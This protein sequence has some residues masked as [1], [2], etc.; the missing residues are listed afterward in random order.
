MKPKDFTIDVNCPECNSVLPLDFI[1]YD[2]YNYSI[3]YK[4]SPSV[5]CS[6]CGESVYI[7]LINKDDPNG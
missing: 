5:P 6:T 4:Y 7:N 3:D 2:K 1:H